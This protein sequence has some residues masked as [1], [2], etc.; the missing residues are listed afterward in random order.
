M[1]VQRG[2]AGLGFGVTSDGIVSKVL[3]DGCA[4]GLL[5]VGDLVLEVDGQRCIDRPVAKVIQPDRALHTFRVR[6]RNVAGTNDPHGSRGS[7]AHHALDFRG[8]VK[9]FSSAE[10]LA[11]FKAARAPT[12]QPCT[13]LD[14]SM[15]P[16]CPPSNLMQ[17]DNP[18]PSPAAE[19]FTNTAPDSSTM[20][21]CPPRNL[22]EFDDPAPSPAA[23]PFTSTAPV[24]STMAVCPPSNLMEFDYPAP[25][26]AAEPTGNLSCVHDGALHCRDSRT[27]NVAALQRA[28]AGAKKRAHAMSTPA[29]RGA[30]TPV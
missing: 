6:R 14:S 19:P 9:K 15:M 1:R 29:E 4:S 24:S 5:F 18:A 20:P 3:P 28:R 22:M 2:A 16:V 12:T 7:T 10:L 21:V 11:Q 30:V 17:F 13:A 27:T 23:E 8:E 25:L 26:P